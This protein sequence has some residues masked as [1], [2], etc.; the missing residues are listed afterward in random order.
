MRDVFIWAS[1]AL[2]VFSLVMIA[3]LDWLRLTLPRRRVI[4]RVTGHRLVS[5]TDGTGY[6]AIY[7]FEAEGGSH[8]VIDQVISSRRQPDPGSLIELVYPA[9]H[10]ALARKP[11]LVMWAIAYA[12][13]IGLT[14]FLVALGL[15]WVK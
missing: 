6:S 5:D 1:V 15:G 4:A 9:G 7:V 12:F 8:E 13:L 3:R 2:C 10:P 11:R 14:G